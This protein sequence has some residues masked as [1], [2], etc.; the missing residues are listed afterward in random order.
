LIIDPNFH[1]VANHFNF[2]FEDPNSSD[3]KKLIDLLDSLNL[4]QGHTL[5]LVLSRSDD[6][7]ISSVSVNRLLLSD[8]VEILCEFNILKPPNKKVLV[9]K[10]RLISIDQEL[11]S[12]PIQEEA[13]NNPADREDVT[14]PVADE[15][16]DE[17]PINDQTKRFDKQAF[18]YDEA[19]D[20]YYCPAGKVLSREGTEKTRRSGEVVELTIYRCHTVMVVRW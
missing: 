17:L 5:D 12:P 15:A 19:T 9:E 6:K 8:R 13:A 16:L 7:L 11:L 20:C 10:R 18:I 1:F 14:E 2:H 4:V 3:T